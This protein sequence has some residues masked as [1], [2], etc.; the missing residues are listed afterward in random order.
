MIYLATE[1][2]QS[3]SDKRLDTLS[4][5]KYPE[6]DIQKAIKELQRRIKQYY[7]KD[8]NVLHMSFELFCFELGNAFGDKLV[9]KGK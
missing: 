7:D 9:E 3:L 6:E 8:T 1:K 2:K 5:F 4:G